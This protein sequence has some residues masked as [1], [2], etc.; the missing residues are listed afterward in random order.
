M[1]GSTSPTGTRPSLL[2]RQPLTNA[3]A[4]VA[5]TLGNRFGEVQE[6]H[7]AALS[8]G[9]ESTGGVFAVLIRAEHGTC[10]SPYSATISKYIEVF[11]AYWDNGPSALIRTCRDE[12][13]PTKDD[14]QHGESELSGSDFGG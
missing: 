2:V 13:T 11:P 8:A 3:A 14:N 7:C 12:R 6:V 1:Q 10:I 9:I 4:Q 5:I